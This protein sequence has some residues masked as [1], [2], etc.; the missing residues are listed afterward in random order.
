MLTILIWFLFQFVWPRSSG[1]TARLECRPLSLDRNQ[2]RTISLVF[3]WQLAASIGATPCS[4]RRR[5]SGT[6]SGYPS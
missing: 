2:H 6:S 1:D 4:Q 5:Y 3:L